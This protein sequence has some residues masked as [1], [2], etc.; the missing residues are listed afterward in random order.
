MEI[1]IQPLPSRM[2]LEKICFNVHG[3]FIDFHQVC[4][5]L[6]TKEINLLKI[7]KKNYDF[8][9]RSPII[10]DIFFFYQPHSA[11]ILIYCFH[12]DTPTMSSHLLKRQSL[13]LTVDIYAFYMVFGSID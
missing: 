1:I 10:A 12:C 6:S 11:R 7:N 3:V 5:I 9:G 8:V 4:R 13:V 2:G